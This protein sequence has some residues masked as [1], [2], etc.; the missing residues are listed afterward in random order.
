MNKVKSLP[1]ITVLVEGENELNYWRKMGFLGNAKKFNLWQAKAST[2][3]GLLRKI[4]QD[5]QIIVIA[6]TDVLTEQNNFIQN[7]HKLKKHCKLKP[8]IIWQIQNFE[9]E[10]CFSC[11]CTCKQLFNHFNAKGTNE[12]KGNF[13]AENQ[14]PSKLKACNHDIEKMWLRSGSEMILNTHE[15]DDFIKNNSVLIKR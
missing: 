12:F 15:I 9:D 5:E 7:F 13:N 11:A 10:L 6:D 14:L 8:Q 4:S 3:S 2:M 1:K